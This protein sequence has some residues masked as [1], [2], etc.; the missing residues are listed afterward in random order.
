MSGGVINVKYHT[1]I[2]NTDEST[3]MPLFLI[4]QQKV[5]GATKISGKNRIYLGYGTSFN[6][7][8]KYSGYRNLSADNFYFTTG[9][10]V[11]VDDGPDVSG[12][13]PV[14]GTGYVAKS[15]NSST[16]Q[17]SFYN[18]NSYMNA[19]LYVWLIV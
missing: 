10:S 5:A 15:Y 17:L 9:G 19:S 14:E 8:S 11:E 16:G 2:R 1:I 7:A 4:T 13:G 18:T 6:V 12:A 3:A